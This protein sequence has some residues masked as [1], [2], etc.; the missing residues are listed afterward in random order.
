M[1]EKV[2]LALKC[3]HE[4]GIVHRDVK[5]E[6][7]MFESKQTDCKLKLVDFGLA[8]QLQPLS[9]QS[10]Q[11]DSQL[12]SQSQSSQPQQWEKVKKFAG[13]PEFMAP[14]VWNDSLYDTKVDMWSAGCVLYVLLCGVMPFRF[15]EHRSFDVFGKN[16]N[17]PNFDALIDNNPFWKEHVSDSAKDLV[18]KLLQPSPDL[19]ISADEAILHPWLKDA[20]DKIVND[21][22]FY[23]LRATRIR[24]RF[25][26]NVER[27][28]AVERIIALLSA[29]S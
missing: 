16:I 21:F 2:V 29:E 25:I 4:R 24:A 6:N 3:L 26:R 7:L 11:T 8:V 23:Q 22:H 5:P 9:T 20:S 12:Q 15:D 18:K 28:L 14:E 27:V 10:E 1:F 17:S 13:T 19:R